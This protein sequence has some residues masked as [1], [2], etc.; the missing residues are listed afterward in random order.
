MN[1]KNKKRWTIA[2]ILTTVA[3][4]AITVPLAV[5]LSSC[6]SGTKVKYE[7]LVNPKD[8]DGKLMS[9]GYK[10]IQTGETKQ[11]DVTY[12]AAL[13]ALLENTSTPSLILETVD[14]NIIVN[15]F[16][17]IKYS[18]NYYEE[19]QN[20][21]KDTDK[22]WKETVDSI[23]EQHGD[24]WQYFLQNDV[25]DQYGGTVENWY[26]NEIS[27]RILSSFDNIMT[28]N[29]SVGIPNTDITKFTYNDLYTKDSPNSVWKDWTAGKRN[30]LAFTPN[31]ASSQGFDAAAS[32]FQEF[33][34]DQYV[35]DNMP[36][37]TSMVLFKHDATTNLGDFFDTNRIKN[38]PQYKDN[39]IVGTAGSYK[40]QAY[41]D[42]SIV[43]D[44]GDWNA[45]D[46]YLNFI[47][48][49][50]DNG[51]GSL[52]NDIGGSIDI[53]V[54]YTDDSATLYKINLKDVFSTSFTPYAA[55]STY[56]F[57]TDVLG[58]S[59]DA[60]VPKGSTLATGLDSTAGTE[61]MSNFMK[62]APA[63]GYFALPQDVVNIMSNGAGSSPGFLAKYNGVKAIADIVN[64]DGTPFI[65]ARN[66]AG[67]HI[68]GIDRL[69]AMK[70]AAG[71][72]YDALV[73]EIK[74]T[75]LWR[76][77]ASKVDGIKNTN[78]FTIDVPSDVSSYYSSN[79]WQLIFKYILAKQEQRTSNSAP[80]TYEANQ[81][82]DEKKYIFS[83]YYTST[84]WD[85]GV[86]VFDSNGRL[87]P[88]ANKE[89]GKDDVLIDPTAKLTEYLL[90]YLDYSSYDSYKDGPNTVTSKLLDAQTAYEGKWS[91]NSTV[92]NGIAGQLPFSGN[93]ESKAIANDGLAFPSILQN[94]S[95]DGKAKPD[96][97]YSVDNEK[98]KLDEFKASADALFQELNGG[99]DVSAGAQKLTLKNVEYQKYEQNAFLDSPAIKQKDTNTYSSIMNP[100]NTL[101]NT[102]NTDQFKLAAEIDKILAQIDDRIYKYDGQNP[103]PALVGYDA[104]KTTVPSLGGDD[105]SNVNNINAYISNVINQT[106]W[107]PSYTSGN[108]SF[109][110][111]AWIDPTENTADYSKLLGIAYKNASKDILNKYSDTTLTFLKTILTLQ[112]AF[113]W[114]AKEGKYNFT[115]F[116]DYLMDS[117]ENYQ[118]AAFVWKVSDDLQAFSTS[119][120]YGQ[121]LTQ[122]FSFKNP[123]RLTNQV[124]GYAYSSLK[125]ITLDNGYYDSS[126]V[127]LTQDNA[128]FN[129]VGFD[130]DNTK[131][132][133]GFNGIQFQSSNNLESSESQSLFSSNLKILN[134]S[135][136]TAASPTANDWIS[137]GALFNLGEGETGRK[138]LFDRIK[139]IQNWSQ[140]ASTRDWLK[141]NFNCDVDE[142]NKIIEDGKGSNASKV[143]AINKLAEIANDP[144][145]LPNA[146]F[147][148]AQGQVANSS[149]VDF[150]PSIAKY[151]GSDKLSVGQM[152]VSQFNRDD[153]IKLFDTSSD[154]KIDDNDK[155]INWAYANTNGFL[156]ASAQAFFFAAYKWATSD[157][158]FTSIAYNDMLDVQN[159]PDSSDPE[160]K[161]LAVKTYTRPL[162]DTFGKSWSENYKEPVKVK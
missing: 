162:N 87:V 41:P 104:S 139:S 107:V 71:Q 142:V 122:D 45:T 36:L 27:S 72:S 48:A 5:T 125:P 136:K 37:V 42:A 121:N 4:V 60:N 78:G 161:G 56:K 81:Q 152:V 22:K 103:S 148:R 112:Y 55:A 82:Y 85:N 25:L 21:L 20:I 65:L 17:G 9:Y 61:I 39:D 108:S 59:A 64:L 73:N 31:N 12:A 157:Q 23:K 95:L 32:D 100:I 98:T 84:K 16:A 83:S 115:K 34:F 144:L 91:T 145:Q 18:K 67:V 127:T 19:Y 47:K 116:R 38:M 158:T 28:S 96:K 3:V 26:Y 11:V 106:L 105:K 132:Y 77:V 97:P 88:T 68:I 63:T 24:S 146:L 160:I 94:L 15:W 120:P 126:K 150:E 117:T 6:S 40:F 1:K 74:N 113:D 43:S 147:E 10:D 123:I 8:G 109:S 44:T 133:T 149:L 66:E 86:P 50:G 134:E 14:K 69:K 35:R 54:R 119:K 135:L 137:K 79:K 89:E 128:Y 49:Y 57:N 111:G 138:V 151:F 155:G 70:T 131:T 46:K 7:N 75:L 130:K 30:K 29:M 2:G 140:I 114:D 101:L 156:G 52:N 90:K 92:A 124:N 80:W 110:F 99:S 129:N 153:V 33:V 143:E 93:Y 62:T 118:K 51:K 141:N 13:K 154:G 58:I 159:D 102:N 53:N 76:Y